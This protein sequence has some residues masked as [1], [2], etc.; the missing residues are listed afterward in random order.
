MAGCAGVALPTV[1]IR[2]PAQNLNAC[3]CSNAEHRQP[4]I[5][6]RSTA[7]FG[8]TILHSPAPAVTLDDAARRDHRFTDGNRGAMGTALSSCSAGI[9]LGLLLIQ[10]RTRSPASVVPTEDD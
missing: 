3:V 1:L 4:L 8:R 5:G 9:R 6:N 2:Q 7:S 10:Q